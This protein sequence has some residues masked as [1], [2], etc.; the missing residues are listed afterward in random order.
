LRNTENF[1]LGRKLHRLARFFTIARFEPDSILVY[2]LIAFAG[3]GIYE[4]GFRYL[5]F[6]PFFAFIL[7]LL[8]ECF[9]EIEIH[10]PAK[11]SVVGSRCIV[12]N[13]ISKS[14][15]GVVKL[16]EESGTL[17]EWELWSAD[18]K[19]SIHWGKS[20]WSNRSRTA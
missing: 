7:L 16:M 12:V 8:V 5:A 9:E 2:S 1:E 14:N 15:R 6:V 18:S 10:H 11:T 17:K 20:R 4:E 19:Y 3:V 13:S